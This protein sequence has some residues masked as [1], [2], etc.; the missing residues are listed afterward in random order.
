MPRVQQRE[1]GVAEEPQVDD[2]PRDPP[3]LR[4]NAAVAAAQATA[5]SDAHTPGTELIERQQHCADRQHEQAA[6][7]GVEA[8]AAGGAASAGSSQA[9]RNASRASGAR[10]QNT[11]GQ[12]ISGTS[13]PAISGP[14]APPR[15]IT[16][17]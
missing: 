17:V 12:S 2:R 5:A 11:A 4:H 3:L 14:S 10:N 15:P 8:F 16:M 6:A 9:S 7:G 1:V 13:S